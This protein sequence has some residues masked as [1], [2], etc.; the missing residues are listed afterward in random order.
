MM[1][2]E[3]VKARIAELE[4]ARIQH[5]NTAG[6]IELIIAELKAVIAPVKECENA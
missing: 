2:E 1:T 4:Q 3:Q 6:A 5:L